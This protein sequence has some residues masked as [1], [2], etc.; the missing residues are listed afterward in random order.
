MAT[1][2]GSTGDEGSIGTPK[3]AD[4]VCL[5]KQNDNPVNAGDDHIQAERSRTVAV[6]A[7]DGVTVVVMFAIVW[8]LERV[9]HT[10]DDNEKP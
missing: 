4:I 2:A 7:P 5:Q 8:G 6:L 1:D 10:R 3:I 9:V